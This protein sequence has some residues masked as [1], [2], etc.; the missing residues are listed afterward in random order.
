MTAVAGAVRPALSAKH[1]MMSGGTPILII[2]KQKN[3][4][5]I[6]K[7]GVAAAFSIQ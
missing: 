3:A 4:R 6:K 5:V 7:R 1:A 2:A